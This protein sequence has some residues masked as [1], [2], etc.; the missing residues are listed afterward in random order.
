LVRV[1]CREAP[2]DRVRTSI[3]TAPV[4]RVARAFGPADPPYPCVAHASLDRAARHRDALPPQ[5]RM[6][7]LCPVDAEVRGVDPADIDQSLLVAQCSLRGRAGLARVVR[8]RR[9][10]RTRCGQRPTD[11]LDAELMLVLV[12]V[13]H[14]QRCGRSS[15]AAKKAEADLRIEF[16]RR[17]SR[18]SFS[19]SIKRWD[20]LVVVPGRYPSSTSA[21]TTQFLRVSGLIPSCSPTRR[22]VPDLV[23]GSR[24][25]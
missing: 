9:D 20:S 4:D 16:A 7:L 8:A 6:D 3:R 19:S 1:A 13:L 21:C 11:R 24:R 10:L 23:D 12:Y 15:S 2:F 5:L 17:S 22:N 25:A 18:T 14:D